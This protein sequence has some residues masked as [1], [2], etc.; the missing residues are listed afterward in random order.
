[1]RRP[2]R[3]IPLFLVALAAPAAV[4]GD[5]PTV[6]PDGAVAR[7]DRGMVLES[8]SEV[9]PDVTPFAWTTPAMTYAQRHYAHRVAVTIGINAYKSQPWPRLKAAVTDAQHMAALFRA[10]GFD[11]VESLEDDAATRDGILDILER[12]LPLLVGERDLVVVFFAGH[13]AT[14][15]GEGYIVPSDANRDLANT[16]ISVERL[17]ASVLRMRVRHTLFLMDACFS[18]VMLRRAEVDEANEANNLSYW[19]AAAQD[20]VVQILTAG[21]AEEP[22]HE[23]NGWGHFTRAVYTGLAG[24]ADRN[25]DGVVTTAELAVY[26]YDRVLREGQGRQHPQWGT[27][28]GS[29]TE[30]FLDVRRL[31]RTAQS[32]PPRTRSMVRGLEVPLG[33]I[34]A[35]M[36]RRE[37]AKAEKLL[38]DLMIKHG[39]SELRLLLAEVYIEADTLGN[40]SLIDAELRRV[41]KSKL[42]PEQQWRML[43]LRARLDKARRGPL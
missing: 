37:W 13:G 14:A 5:P 40:E 29:G 35:L 39:D 34:D 17:K 25:Q 8:A 42:T 31:P 10:I 32:T 19:E 9:T 20:R 16:A 43:D 23:N 6:P 36:E 38:R 2:S 24:A 41:A 33:R 15:G 26:T 3:L 1:M 7:P 22:V 28:E 27:M 18:G 30:F 4:R 21:M 12:K 11:R